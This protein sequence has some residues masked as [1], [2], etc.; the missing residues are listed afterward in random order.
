MPRKDKSSRPIF[1]ESG[2]KTPWHNHPTRVL[3]KAGSQM[4]RYRSGHNEAV[5]KT[6]WGK[7]RKGSNPF[8]S[9]IGGG[10]LVV[11]TKKGKAKTSFLFYCSLLLRRLLA[12]RSGRRNDVA[13]R[14]GVAPL[15]LRLTPRDESLPLRHWRR[16]ARGSNIRKKLLLVVYEVK[17]CILT[18]Q[19]RNEKR[20]GKNAF[21]F[22]FFFLLLRR[23]LA[24]R[25]GVRN[26][27]ADLRS[28]RLSP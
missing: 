9:A 15:T 23:L 10:W 6:V 26:N 16:L 14:N 13:L 24:S 27:V 1:R 18:R 17:P 5:L 22:S 20:K 25:S 21:P 11:A 19:N 8:L 2:W 3:P 4:E 28:R 7:P 12:S